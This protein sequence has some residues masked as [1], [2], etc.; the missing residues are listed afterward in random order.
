MC[1]PKTCYMMASGAIKYLPQ[2]RK[3]RHFSLVLEVPYIGRV[4]TNADFAK[5]HMRN[6]TLCIHRT[7]TGACM[8][9]FNR[10]RDVRFAHI[11]ED[12]RRS[13]DDHHRLALLKPTE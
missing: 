13:P 12:T 9:E 1:E 4:T 5:A 10:D 3:M 2:F 7:E 6:K 11:R 8:C